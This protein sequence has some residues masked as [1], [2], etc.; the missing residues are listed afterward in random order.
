MPQEIFSTNTKGKLLSSHQRE[1]QN[2]HGG[3]ADKNPPANEGTWV[4]SLRISEDFTCREATKPMRHNSW[5]GDL[6]PAGRNYGSM[7]ML[8][9]VSTTRETTAMRSLCTATKSSACSPQ[10]EKAQMRQRRP[11]ATKNHFFFFKG[12]NNPVLQ[13]YL[14][15]LGGHQC[16]LFVVLTFITGCK[17]W[18]L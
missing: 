1:K 18:A 4:R 6:E 13:R 14:T 2:F 10:L 5:V 12:R 8:E 16:P 3:A 11:S 7:H 15:Q 17:L 9:P